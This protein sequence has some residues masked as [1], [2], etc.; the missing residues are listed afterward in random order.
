LSDEGLARGSK[1][2]VGLAVPVWPDCGNRSGELIDLQ[3]E[4]ISMKT[5]AAMVA[6]SLGNFVSKD[7]REVFGSGH[8][9]I[10]ERLGTLARSTVE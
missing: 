10:A 9:D 1:R 4:L 8:Q 7:F 5:I 3:L 6:K 2:Q